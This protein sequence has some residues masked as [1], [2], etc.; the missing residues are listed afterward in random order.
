MCLYLKQDA[1]KTE[2]IYIY[3]K[4]RVTTVDVFY[5]EKVSPPPQQWKFHH[6]VAEE[7]AGA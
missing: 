2:C 7:G 4:E 1:N 6:R 3:T 5:C